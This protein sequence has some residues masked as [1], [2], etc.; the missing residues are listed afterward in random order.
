[1]P[2]SRPRV[3]RWGTYYGKRHSQ[4]VKESAVFFKGIEYTLP[5]FIDPVDVHLD[6]FVKRPKTTKRLFPVGDV[7]NYAKIILDELVKYKILRDDDLV[8]KLKVKK[9]FADNIEGTNVTINK[10]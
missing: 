2:A 8:L 9:Q 5:N 7:D 4:Y 6:L 1:V 10:L 3:T